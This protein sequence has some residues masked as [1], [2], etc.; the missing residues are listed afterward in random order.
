MT[1][2]GNWIQRVSLVPTPQTEAGSHVHHVTTGGDVT[3]YPP[4]SEFHMPEE[5]RSARLVGQTPRVWR[6][7]YLRRGPPRPTEV[8]DGLQQQAW[9]KSFGASEPNASGIVNVDA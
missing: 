7:L 6:P 3:T 1:A 5:T 4:V 2:I 8:A 9:K